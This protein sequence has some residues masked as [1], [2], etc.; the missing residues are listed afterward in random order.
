MPVCRD[1][2]IVKSGYERAARKVVL[3]GIQGTN[4]S[5][6]ARVY[7]PLLGQMDVLVGETGWGTVQ[8]SDEYWDNWSDT[9][10]AAFSEKMD[11]LVANLTSE[12][13]LL[14]E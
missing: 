1:T 14:Q 7:T 5:H 11:P 10:G 6:D 9:S 8:V 12:L 13:F 2:C 4:P 3:E